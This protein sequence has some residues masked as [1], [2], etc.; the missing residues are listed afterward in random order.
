VLRHRRRGDAI[1]LQRALA[2]HRHATISYVTNE[3][4][5]FC[6]SVPYL[7]CEYSGYFDVDI[8]NAVSSSWFR[9][10]DL[11]SSFPVQNMPV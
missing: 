5:V 6:F 4:E 1:A 10:E 11:G 9:Y 3:I 7:F 2:F 8:L